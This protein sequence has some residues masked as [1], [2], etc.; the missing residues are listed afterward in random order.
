MRYLSI[1]NFL[2]IT[3]FELSQYQIL[4]GLKRYKEQ[5]M[6]SNVFPALKELAELSSTLKQIKRKNSRLI[7]NF[8]IPVKN[9]DTE[10]RQ[11]EFDSFTLYDEDIARI[12]DLIKWAIPVV[13]AAIDDALSI[14]KVIIEETE[15]KEV[16]VH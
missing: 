2:C 10:K 15:E 14:K 5:F 3:D 6:S 1:E 7:E 12:L 9:I 13:D 4:A 11:V 16:R 8:P